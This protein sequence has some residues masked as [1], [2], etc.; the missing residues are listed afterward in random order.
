M[1][2]V[3]KIM[4]QSQRE[5]PKK[6]A[7][8]AI[9]NKISKILKKH[10]RRSPTPTKTADIVPPA[11]LEMNLTTGI[12]KSTYDYFVV[13]TMTILRKILEWLLPNIPFTIKVKKLFT[14]YAHIFR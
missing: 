13:P 3:L 4:N 10:P 6:T 7:V 1:K 9:D 14:K 5:V 8:H 12:P 2:S 11:L